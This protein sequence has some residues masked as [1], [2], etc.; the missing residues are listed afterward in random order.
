MPARNVA[1]FAQV[2]RCGGR[3]GSGFLTLRA[4]VTLQS[5]IVPPRGADGAERRVLL[6]ERDALV[7]ERVRRLLAGDRL[8]VCHVDSPALFDELRRSIEFSV[9]VVGV[10][11]EDALEP[12]DL[13]EVE[14]LILLADVMEPGAHAR[15]RLSVPHAE[16]VDRSLR[17]PDVF[18]AVLAASQDERDTRGA[19]IENPVRQA[20][21]PFGLSERQLEVLSSALMGATSKEIAQELFISELTVRNHLHAIYERVGVSGRREL[22]GR[23]VRGLIEAHA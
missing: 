10:D 11:R 2:C 16:L 6:F 4:R 7:A 13:N 14:P 12:L 1:R 8:R 3:T 18:R 15:Y 20:F 23:F 19:L 5:E 9:I 21:T 17:D 22:L